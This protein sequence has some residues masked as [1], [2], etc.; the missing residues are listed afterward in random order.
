MLTAEE[1]RGVRRLAA[2]VMSL[3]P[4]SDTLPH[5]V[6]VA[7]V[8][9][10]A[11]LLPEPP[12]TAGLAA[13]LERSAGRAGRA[14]YVPAL[15][16]TAAELGV[17]ERVVSE[18][19]R[20]DDLVTSLAGVSPAAMPEVDSV[21]DEVA[22]DDFG[23]LVHRS[24]VV[25]EDG[26]EVPAYA[27]GDPGAPAIA[28]VAACGMPARLAEN[29][30]RYL[31]EDFYVVTWETRGLFGNDPGHFAHA[32]GMAAQTGDLFDVLDHFGVKEAHLAGLCAGSSI[33]LAAAHRA[34]ERFSSLSLWHGGYDMG[35]AVPRTAHH[36]N[37]K[38]LHEMVVQGRVSAAAIHASLTQAALSGVPADLAH[39]V[40]YPYATPELLE[41]YCRLNGA[42]MHVDAR[43]YL[44]P[45]IPRTLV[46][47]SGDDRTA[48]PEGSRYVAERLPDAELMVR[49]SGDHL[50]LFQAGPELL[51][52]AADF[53]GGRRA[54]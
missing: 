48:H 15:H 27:A 11:A 37:L 46:V 18:H 38:A 13:V 43:P 34:P 32:T 53:A 42:I 40:L 6:R 50:S 8:K 4:L 30:V 23:G 14:H 41:L 21:L 1:H 33:A 44:S 22:R 19:L 9:P 17:F 45:R 24:R 35:E 12:D 16:T 52:V 5:P 20:V 10:L 3:A 36:R 39:L 28:L 2:A 54:S 49:P 25:T 31:A 26:A 47:T 51:R 29:W 7:P